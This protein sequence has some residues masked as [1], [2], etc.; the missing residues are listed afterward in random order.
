VIV[1]TKTKAKRYERKKPATTAGFFR[2]YL[3]AFVFVLTITLGGFFFTVIQHVT[4][5]GWSVVLRR[6]GETIASNF[7]WLWILF[8]PILILVATGK[9]GLLYPWLDHEHA[10]ADHVLQHKAG[11]LNQGFWLVRAVAY[12]A[13]WFLITGFY[14]RNSV[15]QDHSGDASLTSR[16]QWWAPLGVIA[17]A[18]TTTFAAVDWVMS[19][20]PH[21][22]STI[23]GVYFFAIS[24]CGFF[25]TLILLNFLLHRSGKL[26]EVTLEHWQDMGKLLFAFGVVFHTYIGFSQFMLIWYANIPE[27]TGWY[28]ARTTPPWQPLMWLLLVGHFVVPFLLLVTKHTKRARPILAAIAVWMLVIHALD[29]YLLVMPKVPHEVIAHAT[30]VQEVYDAAAADPS[31]VGWTPGLMDLL[32]L[33]GLAGIYLAMTARRLGRHALLPVQDPRLHESLAFE[34]M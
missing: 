6:V 31:I 12:F 5:A 26:P 3:F 14:Y 19:L 32:C 21:W 33:V 10:A 20:E 23:F 7:L 29:L 34:N 9:G 17:F 8:L 13:L 25:S 24:A 22:F 2:S 28:V 4:R 1:S 27:E 16:M 30:T 18:L 11:Y 15:A